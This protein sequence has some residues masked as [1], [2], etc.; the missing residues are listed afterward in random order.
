MPQAV[1]PRTLHHVGVLDIPQPHAGSSGARLIFGDL[2]WFQLG[3]FIA[4]NPGCKLHSAGHI[5]DIVW[6]YC[7]LYRALALV[8]HTVSKQTQTQLFK[9]TVQRTRVLIRRSETWCIHIFVN[10]MR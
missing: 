9:C 7:C 8:W 1:F 5:L 3:N 10:Q 2:K 4:S 6:V